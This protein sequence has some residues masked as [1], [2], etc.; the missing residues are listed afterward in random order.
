MTNLI[1]LSRTQGN[2]LDITYVTDNNITFNI[3]RYLYAL[4]NENKEM[5]QQYL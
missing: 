4:Y 3:N 5:L 2:F 1:I